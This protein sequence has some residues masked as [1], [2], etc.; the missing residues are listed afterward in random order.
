VLLAINGDRV[1]TPADVER[2]ARAQ[3]RNWAIDLVRQGQ[4]V[5]LRFRV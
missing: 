5:R 1:A 3:T 2:A 4:P